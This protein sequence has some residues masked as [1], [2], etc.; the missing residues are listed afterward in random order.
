MSV[1]TTFMSV[2][3]I[4]E[5]AVETTETARASKNG[6]KS[7]GE[8]LEN[9]AQ[10]LCIRYPITFWK[11]FVSMLV[12][13]DLDSEVNAIYPTFAWELKLLIRSTDVKAQKINGTT[14]DIFGIVVTTFLVTDRANWVRFFEKTFLVA[15]VNPKIVFG[16]PFLTL[17]GADVNFLDQK[18]RWKT[19]TT[20][21][22]LLTTRYV[23]LVGKKEFAAAALDPEYET[24][25][26]YVGLFN[27]VA[28][29]SPFLLD[30][31]PSCRPQIADLIA[32]RVFTKVPI[33]YLDFAD[34]FSPDLAT[35]LPKPTGINEHA[36]KLVNG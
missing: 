27:S 4:R 12:L 35:K 24:Y 9:F 34:V 16:M 15:N 19:Y 10:V 33:K 26:V 18:L 21:K 5:E 25:I 6:K 36:I 23:E 22:T 13:F 32:E 2:I 31:H 17:S 8:Y 29:P 1:L 3:G 30:N 28:L 14:L 7:K 11:K 20:E